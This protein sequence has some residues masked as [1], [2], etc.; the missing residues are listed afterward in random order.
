M[1]RSFAALLVCAF[2]CSNLAIADEGMWRYNEPPKDKIKAKYGFEMTQEWLDH[3]RLSS[4]RFTNGGSGS[5]VSADGLTFTNHHVGAACVQ[6]LSTEGRDYI[7]TG[8][9]AKT[10]AEEAK[11]PALELNQLVGIEDVTAKVNASVKPGMSAADAGQAQRA[12]MSD[13]E[14]N[15]ST[16]TGLRCDVVIFYSGQVYNLYKY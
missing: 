10:Q 12:A 7:K 4:V 2:V 14:K 11:C 5:F 6:Q 13:V 9:Y 16:S 3:I 8:F 1:K 15:C